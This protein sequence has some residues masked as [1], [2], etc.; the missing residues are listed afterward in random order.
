[1]FWLY[2]QAQSSAWSKQEYWFQAD[3]A[4]TQLQ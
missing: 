4:H 1:M 3:E 2:C